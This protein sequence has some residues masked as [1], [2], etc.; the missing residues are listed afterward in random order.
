LPAH[1]KGTPCKKCGTPKTLWH[2]NARAAAGGSWDCGPCGKARKQTPEYKAYMKA[3]DKARNQTPER[4]ARRQAYF[5][6]WKKARVDA[7]LC[8]GCGDDVGEERIGRTTCQPCID[9]TVARNSEK[10]YADPRYRDRKR[11]YEEQ[12]NRAGRV[13]DKEIAMQDLLGEL[14]HLLG[15]L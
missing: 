13:A 12:R 8:R 4:K 1:P 10:W 11:L 6:A 14:D 5:K 7:G 2:K 15:G 3:Y 9:R